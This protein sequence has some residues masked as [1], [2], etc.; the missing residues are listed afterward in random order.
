MGASAF[1][2]LRGLLLVRAFA[3]AAARL[4][5]LFSEE[6]GDI[7][8]RIRALLIAQ[9]EANRSFNRVEREVTRRLGGRDA[10]DRAWRRRRLAKR[11]RGPEAAAA[12]EQI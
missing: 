1:R 5:L 9:L 8:R 3:A 4:A 12:A 2:A 6:V 10:F 7:F 11:S